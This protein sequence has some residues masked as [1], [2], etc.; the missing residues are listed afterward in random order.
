VKAWTRYVATLHR[1]EVVSTRAP[2]VTFANAFN[3]LC[4]VPSL[5][6]RCGD[7]RL[8][9]GQ[10]FTKPCGECRLRT[11]ILK[12]QS[13]HRMCGNLLTRPAFC[14]M[15]FPCAVIVTVTVSS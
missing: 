1:L 6:K 5:H 8:F 13:A 14:V 7:D 4:H 10:L 15:S 12:C 9:F 11:Y 3:F 2:D